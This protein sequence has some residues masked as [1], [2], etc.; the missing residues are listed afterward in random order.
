[1]V[2][3]EGGD[4]GGGGELFILWKRDEVFV[5][6]AL[7]DRSTVA[8]TAHGSRLVALLLVASSTERFFRGKPNTSTR[9]S[10]LDEAN[11]FTE[12]L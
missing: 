8:Q 3:S 6:V 11:A 5:V 1:M 2:G 12:L 7:V 4:C 9:D 10:A